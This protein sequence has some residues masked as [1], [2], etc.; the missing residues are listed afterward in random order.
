MHKWVL[1]V[2]A[3]AAFCLPGLVPA[4]S[5]KKSADLLLVLAMDSSSSINADRY[6]LQIEGY[7]AALSDPEVVKLLTMRKGTGLIVFEWSNLQTVIISCL[8]IT[9]PQH[10][11]D[12]ADLI[13]NHT[14]VQHS[15]TSVGAAMAFA[16][17]LV[18]ACDITADEVV[19]DVSGDGHDNSSPDDSKPAQVRDRLVD[20]GW[21]I[22]SLPIEAYARIGGADS[23]T[24]LEWYRDNVNGGN[25]NF[26]MPVE[27]FDQFAKQ[28]RR[29]LIMEI[30]QAR[31][32]TYAENQ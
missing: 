15:T 12:A 26:S 1:A 23:P 17:T 18:D 25:G 32:N 16:Q 31:F 13:A 14:R 4:A 8:H 11:L 10:A 3:F 21:R 5:K 7:A 24:L 29:K 28:L 30:S 22:N 27:N 19:L 6:K 20:A 9:K 2:V